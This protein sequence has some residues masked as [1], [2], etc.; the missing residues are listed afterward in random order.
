MKLT[1][2]KIIN[3]SITISRW[4]DEL[5]DEITTKSLTMGLNNHIQEGYS[6]KL[7]IKIG[8]ERIVEITRHL[9]FITNE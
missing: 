3:I 7:F 4:R 1:S 9:P 2:S 6:I 8:E 5:I